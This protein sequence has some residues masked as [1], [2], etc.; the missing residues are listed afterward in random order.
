MDLLAICKH[1]L[2]YYCYSIPVHKLF[3]NH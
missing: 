2:I 1:F 3:I